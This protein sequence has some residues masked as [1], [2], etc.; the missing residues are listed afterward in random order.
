M[1]GPGR[2]SEAIWRSADETSDSRAFSSIQ[3]GVLIYSWFNWDSREE[4]RERKAV[5]VKLHN[6]SLSVH[7]TDDNLF[8]FFLPSR[9][10]ERNLSCQSRVGNKNASIQLSALKLKLLPLITH[11]LTLLFILTNQRSKKKGSQ[12]GG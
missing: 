3:G 2:H 11:F 12:G 9:R 6:M 10:D 5:R 7:T 4:K 1:L 8:I